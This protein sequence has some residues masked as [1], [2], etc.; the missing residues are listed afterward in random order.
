MMFTG[1]G[2]TAGAVFMEW[3]I[4]ESEQGSAAMW[5][6]IFRVGGAVG[7][8]LS[9]TN[10]HQFG[11]QSYEK[12]GGIT[13]FPKTPNIHRCMASTMML[14]VTSSASIYLENMWFWVAGRF[15]ELSQSSTHV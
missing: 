2:P 7:T 5:D 10:C 8:G 15:I 1:S 4:H 3:N 13:T 6:T 12:Y 9:E 14:H 11:K